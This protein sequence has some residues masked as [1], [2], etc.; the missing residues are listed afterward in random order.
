[1]FGGRKRTAKSFDRSYFKAKNGKRDNVKTAAP[2][3]DDYDDATS[4][5]GGTFSNPESQQAMKEMDTMGLHQTQ[6]YEAMAGFEQ[7]VLQS[8]QQNQIQMGGYGHGNAI[9][10]T[11]TVP[12]VGGLPMI[13]EGAPLEGIP[14]APL[15]R[16]DLL[17]SQTFTGQYDP[18]GY[19]EAQGVGQVPLKTPGQA[20]R[21]K[22]SP[23]APPSSVGGAPSILPKGLE[24]AGTPGGFNVNVNFGRERKKR[25]EVDQEYYDVGRY[26]FRMS[27]NAESSR[28]IYFIRMVAGGLNKKFLE[29]VEIINEYDDKESKPIG[30]NDDGSHIFPLLSTYKY[31]DL[32]LKAWSG[33]MEMVKLMIDGGESSDT[34]ALYIRLIE[35]DTFLDALADYVVY[36]IANRNRGALVTGKT[37]Y[38]YANDEHQEDVYLEQMMRPLYY[39]FRILKADLVEDYFS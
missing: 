20:G 18:N 35:N 16:T 31:S 6:L 37:K 1:M 23:A 24:S 17:D 15:D 29:L 10:N 38:N 22:A 11:F 25:K 30:T 13:E 2:G 28:D 34:M 12:T 27:N 33:A 39:T 8:Q 5:L 7:A 19:T 36:K 4:I 9:D 14:A 3:D 32:L 26:R 21:P